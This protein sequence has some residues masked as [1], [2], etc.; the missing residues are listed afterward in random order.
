M[1]RGLFRVISTG[2]KEETK[3]PILV[4]RSELKHLIRQG[5]GFST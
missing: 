1:L 2:L 4:S 3:R 5:G